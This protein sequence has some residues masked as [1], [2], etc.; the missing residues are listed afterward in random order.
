VLLAALR[1]G[2]MMMMMIHYTKSTAE[3]IKSGTAIVPIS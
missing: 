2:M 3:E 1:L